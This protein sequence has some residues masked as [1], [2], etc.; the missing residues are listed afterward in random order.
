MKSHLSLLRNTLN[1]EDNE[2]EFKP[3]ESSLKKKRQITFTPY[4]NYYINKKYFKSCNPP[5]W[6]GYSKIFI[7]KTSRGNVN[8]NDPTGKRFGSMYQE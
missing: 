4:D 8:W 1:E 7:S 6:Q 2:K 3:S 5:C